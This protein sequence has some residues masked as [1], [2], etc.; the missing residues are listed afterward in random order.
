MGPSANSS[1]SEAASSGLLSNVFGF[2]S[3]EIESFVV[4]AAGGSA[5]RPPEPGPS[6]SSHRPQRV[7]KKSRRVVDTVYAGPSDLDRDEGPNKDQRAS[8]PRSRRS[9]R[10][11][12]LG[13]PNTQNESVP[14]NLPSRVSREKTFLKPP[15]PTMPGSLF[16]RS[17][18]MAPNITP[19]LQTTRIQRVSSNPPSPT[20]EKPDAT[21]TDVRPTLEDHPVEADI[22]SEEDVPPLPVLSAKAKGKQRAVEPPFERDPGETTTEYEFRGKEWELVNILESHKT[23]QKRLEDGA[24]ADEDRERIELERDRDKERIRVLEHE[25]AQLRRELE[26]R[27]SPHPQRPPSVLLGHTMM[28]PPPPPP[29]P[30][31]S[32]SSSHIPPVR[33]PGSGA[34]STEDFL[35]SARAALKHTTLPVEAPING[36]YASSRTKRTGQP[37]VKLG[38]DK[39]AA[40]LTEMKTAKLR[41]TGSLAS[42]RN[43]GIEVNPLEREAT[44]ASLKR[45][46][47]TGGAGTMNK[48]QRT[49]Q[50]NLSLSHKLERRLTTSNTSFDPSSIPCGD[51]PS[52]T[53]AQPLP[54]VQRALP[55]PPATHSA[56]LPPTIIH[57]TAKPN[58]PTSGSGSIDDTPSLCSDHEPS[59]ENSA[60]DRLPLTPPNAHRPKSKVTGRQ[61]AKEAILINSSP[62]AL[63]RFANK[64]AAERQRST[65]VSEMPPPIALSIATSSPPPVRH[66]TP[67]RIFSK[68]IPSSPMPQM[69]TPN[70]PRRPAKSRVAAVELRTPVHYLSDDELEYASENDDNTLSLFNERSFAGVTPYPKTAATGAL[71]NIHVRR[72]TLDE[73][74]RTAEDDRLFDDGI[75]VGVGTR[76][77]KRGFLKGGGAAGT[78]VLMGVGYVIGAEDSEGEQPV[79]YQALGDVGDDPDSVGRDEEV[80]VRG[81]DGTDDEDERLLT[82]R[83][84]AIQARKAQITKRSWLPVATGS[85]A[86]LRGRGRGRR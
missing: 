11:E 49:D 32:G 17:P 2:F 8:R 77:K 35:S 69:R 43:T 61:L 37:T 57:S 55:A 46:L 10:T 63:T 56:L 83:P 54:K 70:R 62:P 47:S 18:S 85:T 7:K 64:R 79:D 44:T 71:P 24:A 41:K 59:Q 40:F 12:K 31:P 4:N 25:V 45:R 29:P 86:G 75:L 38:G 5:Q 23:A 33:L 82:R 15:P 13:V 84:S 1:K 26:R 58:P 27:R 53:H 22:S 48:R 66:P 34:K 30:P 39:M 42:I 36:A 73:E 21:G 81:E 50:S 19:Q 14:H 67:K 20:L 78:P 52:L 51:L 16:P 60:E 28:P 68:R 80:P 9:H 76:S 74:I 72:K 6:D 3:R 65:D